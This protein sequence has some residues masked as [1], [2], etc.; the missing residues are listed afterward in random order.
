MESNPLQQK[1][2]VVPGLRGMEKHDILSLRRPIVDLYRQYQE[3]IE[4]GEYGLILGDDVS[5]RIPTLI[6]SEVI[7][8]TYEKHG[9]TL[10]L[11][12]FVAGGYHISSK[13]DSESKDQL[14]RRMLGT[15]QLVRSYVKEMKARDSGARA[16]LITE[17][18]SYGAALND[19][20]D[21]IKRVGIDLDVAAV[22]GL[23]SG[24]ETVQKKHGV[25]VSVGQE[26]VPGIYGHRA[27]TGLQ[28]ERGSPVARALHQI[29]PYTNVNAPVREARELV[30]KVALGVLEDVASTK[31]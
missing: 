12:R 24:V 16:L 17:G 4:G 10:P 30:H 9:N 8:S 7:K 2:E 23:E 18:I 21:G 26:H 13:Y 31:E 11:T 6:L 1:K 20:L 25:R 27:L 14:E 28:K 15:E 29:H 22:G 19:L 5:G 3:E